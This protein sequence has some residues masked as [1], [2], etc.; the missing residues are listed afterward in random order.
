[1]VQGVAS[2]GGRAPVTWRVERSRG[3]AALFH[4]RPLP[5]PIERSVW[6]HDLTESALVLG[7]SQRDDILAQPLPADIEV[8]RRHSGGGVVL[9]VPGEVLWLDV[10]IPAGDGLWHDD[11]G[12]ASH[13]LGEV[14]AAVIGHGAAVHRDGMVVTPWSKL[15]CFAGIGPGEVLVGAKKVVGV[16]QRRTRAGARFQCALYAS[17]D[18]KLLP[19]LLHL[20][21]VERDSLATSLQKGVGMCPEPLETVLD[22]FLTYLRDH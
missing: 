10:V 19:T 4:A 17:M 1:M 7:S 12:R 6:I 22:R 14:W 5:E 8:V 2:I 18:P 11:I 21:P 3:S 15:V 16:S 20:D 13:W 9:L